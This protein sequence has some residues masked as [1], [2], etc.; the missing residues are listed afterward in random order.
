MP[1]KKKSTIRKEGE[2]VFILKPALKNYGLDYLHVELIA[3][4]VILVVLAF[5]LASFKPGVV[6]K[7][8]AYGAVN[9]TCTEPAHNSTQALAAAERVIA[10][11]ATINTSFSLLPYYALVNESRASYLPGQRAWFIVVPY[12]NP[13]ISNAIFNFSM[14]LSDSNL[15]LE[16]SFSPMIKP[17]L[18][19]N[20]TVVAPG[21]V[22]LYGAAL[23]TTSK[24]V[25]V[26]IV[27]DPYSTGAL[28]ALNTALN[29]SKRFGSEINMSYYFIF[30]GSAISFYNGYGMEATQLLGRY[31]S[32]AS[33]QGNFGDFLSNLSIAYAGV[34]LYNSTLYEVAQGSSLNMSSLNA[35]MANSITSLNYQAK[36]AEL[37]NVVTTPEFIVNCK[38]ATIPQT[39]NMA[40]NY[41][42][43]QTKG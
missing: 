9:G 35:C 22:S 26:Y 3:L 13:F 41:S 28:P 14:L 7:S 10:S 27:T 23:C 4:V 21:V 34:P 12:I 33:R 6:I 2:P 43:S 40:I 1:A 42:L 31:L 11:Y 18:Y 15:S 39:L 29:A 38:Y 19:T 30:A 24:P 8:C 17:V 36:L 37:Y 5:A 20:N 25:P 32:C 16:N